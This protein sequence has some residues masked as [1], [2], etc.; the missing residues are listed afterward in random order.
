[1]KSRG[2]KACAGK[3][4]WLAGWA[5][6]EGDG[7][8]P[9]AYSENLAPPQSG[10]H[11]N[12]PHFF[13]V[14]KRGTKRAPKR[15]GPFGGALEKIG[16]N[17][18]AGSEGDS[19]LSSLSISSPDLK[20]PPGQP[21]PPPSESGN[22][23]RHVPAGWGCLGAWGRCVGKGRGKSP[24]QTLRQKVEGKRR[25]RTP[26]SL[27]FSCRRVAFPGGSSNRRFHVTLRV[28]PETRGRKKLLTG[29]RARSEGTGGAHPR[30]IPKTKPPPPGRGGAGVG[31]GQGP[32]RSGLRRSG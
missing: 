29:F 30:F 13:S 9:C 3:S 17:P 31:P 7:D 4:F 2:S 19:V 18:S 23:Q 12:Q 1:M 6:A 24:T 14:K 25:G 26:P 21:P 11:V 22:P 20:G 5:S 32:S 15:W 10:D 27:S 8:A 16:P 28:G